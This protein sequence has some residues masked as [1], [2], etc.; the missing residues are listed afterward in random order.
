MK[1]LI[2]YLTALADDELV[3]GH[4]DSEWTGY[5]PILEED[6]AFSN[7]AQDELGHSLALYSLAE[8][9]GSPS[10]DAMAFERSWNQ[11]RCCRFVQYPKGDFAYTVMRQFLFD[12]AEQ[13]RM[14][15]LASC[16]YDPLRDCSAKILAEEAY[17]LM[18][19]QALIER[20][21]DATEES[22]IRMQTAATAAF[23]QALG[24]FEEFEGE[25]ELVKQRVIVASKTLKDE[26]LSTVIPILTKSSLK[27]PVRGT[28]PE[29]VPD[30]GGR[31]GAHT[32]HLSHL[33][34]D[35][36]KVYQMAPGGSW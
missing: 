23:A 10:P 35:L 3:L 36:Q 6:I 21:G 11:F 18:H 22:H 12:S 13:V 27:L 16:S 28:V 15:S 30:L 34:A 2:T 20:L 19:T 1:D 4:R 8:A 26:W 33:V 9:L 31:K 32:E 7:I 17:H 24:I 25:E 29:C 14:N 5:A